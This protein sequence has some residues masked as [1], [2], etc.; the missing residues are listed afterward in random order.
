VDFK[1]VDEHVRILRGSDAAEALERTNDSAFYAPGQGIVEVSEERWRLAQAA[2]MAHWFGFDRTAADDGNFGHFAAF[3]A[4]RSLK[5][6]QVLHAVEL[7]CGPFTNLRLVARVAN[8]HSCTLV[9]PSV[10]R[11]LHHENRYYDLEYLYL[12]PAVTWMPK[13]WRRAPGPLRTLC[14]RLG[15]TVPVRSLVN[16]GGESF[17][18]TEGCDLLVMVNVLEH[19]RDARAVLSNV[20]AALSTE[21]IVAIGD[22]FFVDDAVRAALHRRYDAAHPLR[23]TQSILDPLL[24]GAEIL[25]DRSIPQAVDG[26]PGTV[27]RYVIARVSR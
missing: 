6:S 3:D 9:D 4:Y 21:A 27:R 23:V 19:C 15:W 1:F 11:Y 16:S 24:E 7:G 18:M 26:Y 14:R 13:P 2:E 12:P 22:V 25:H 8:V 5:D 20:L 10:R 17:C